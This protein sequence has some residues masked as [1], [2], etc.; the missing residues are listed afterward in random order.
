MVYVEYLPQKDE[1]SL[2]VDCRIVGSIFSRDG[3][4]MCS[5]IESFHHIFDFPKDSSEKLEN[6]IEQ[7]KTLVERKIKYIWSIQKRLPKEYFDYSEYENLIDDLQVLDGKDSDIV[8]SRIYYENLVVVYCGQYLKYG[9]L[10]KN[11]KKRNK[12]DDTYYELRLQPKNG[13]VFKDAIIN[14]TEDVEIIKLVETQN[15]NWLQIIA[16]DHKNG[17][18]KII[19]WDFN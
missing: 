11:P 10:E 9:F 14:F 19:T 18:L 13:I 7:K 12:K 17:I 6:I 1:N 2:S 15:R 16:K 5:K 3:E 8:C 4:T